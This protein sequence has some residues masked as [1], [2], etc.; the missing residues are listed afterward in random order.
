M[1]FSPDCLAASEKSPCS[2]PGSDAARGHWRERDADGTWSI[3]ADQLDRAAAD[4]AR[5]LRDQPVTI[6]TV[7]G[8]RSRGSKRPALRHGS[9]MS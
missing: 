3:P 9:I 2:P 5:G 6:E 1:R 7:W 8:S 4:E